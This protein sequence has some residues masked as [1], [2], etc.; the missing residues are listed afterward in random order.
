MS[1]ADTGAQVK[2]K[3]A[4]PQR[5]SYNQRKLPIPPRFHPAA[6]SAPAAFPPEQGRATPLLDIFAVEK[7]GGVLCL[8]AKNLRDRRRVFENERQNEDKS[9]NINGE[10]IAMTGARRRHD[11]LGDNITA[12]LDRQ[13]TDRPARSTP[14]TC[15]SGWCRDGS[16]LTPTRKWSSCA[17]S[18]SSRTASWIRSSNP[19]DF[20][21]VLSEYRERPTAEKVRLYA[22]LNRWSRNVLGARAAHK[23]EH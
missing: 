2:P 3:P 8:P 12:S 21:E 13:L 10:E 1:L 16:T 22:R 14:A 18:H 20:V 19:P 9:E 15:A 4:R 23:V 7:P 5:Y 11:T 17:A 6:R